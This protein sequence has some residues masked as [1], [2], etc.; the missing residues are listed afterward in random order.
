MSGE[1]AWFK[2]SYSSS[3]GGN[4]VEVAVSWRESSHS[5]GAGGNRVETA[6]HPGAVHVRDSKDTARPA[7]CATPAAWAAF[8]CRVPD[9]PS[10]R[11]A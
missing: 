10:A 1:L 9:S 7:I 4:C 8:L 3:S 2:S 6:A 5:T 11:A